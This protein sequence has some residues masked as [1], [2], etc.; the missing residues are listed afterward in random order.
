MFTRIDF[1]GTMHTSGGPQLRSFEEFGVLAGTS[2]AAIAME[3]HLA[4]ARNSE[5]GLEEAI[6]VALDAWIVG[7]LSREEGDT[8]TP[9]AIQAA[10]KEQLAG[11]AVEA[12]VLER[13]ARQPA[14][15]RAL[16]AAEIEK[17][18]G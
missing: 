14:T 4:G 8:P 16:R 3:R 9:E 17:A 7:H 13:S 5:L 2:A 15:Y 1:D 10:R 12:A 6:R 11:A 18:V